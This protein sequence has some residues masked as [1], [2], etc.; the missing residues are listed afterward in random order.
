MNPVR[1]QKTSKNYM[2]AEATTRVKSLT[3]IRKQRE[4]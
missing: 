1:T 2:N 4:F 3:N